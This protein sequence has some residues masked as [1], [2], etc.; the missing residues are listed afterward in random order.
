M[1]VGW[2]AM[3]HANS[4]LFSFFF[5]VPPACTRV[6][7]LRHI[8]KVRKWLAT[9]DFAVLRKL[10]S[11]QATFINIYHKEI[12]PNVGEYAI[13]GSYGICVI[14]KSLVRLTIG[15]FLSEHVESY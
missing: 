12:Q 7:L 5:Q 15:K 4:Q 10:V 9:L 6:A 13:Q 14:L 2:P 8:L 3:N 11:T 1:T